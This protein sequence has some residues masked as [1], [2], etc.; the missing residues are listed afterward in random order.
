MRKPTQS[1]ESRIKR[2][3]FARRKGYVFTPSD[4]LDLARRS[5][6]DVSLH[7]LTVAGIIRRVARG[8]YLY[9]KKDH[10]LLGELG[11]S[12]EAIVAALAARDHVRMQPSGAY[13]ANMLRLSEQVPAKVVFVTD[14]RARKMKFGN[15]VIE[16]RH[17]TP[18]RMVAGT[19]GLVIAALRYLGKTHVSAAR[20]AHLREIL[21]PEDRKRLLLDLPSAP[22]WLHS[23][24]RFIAGKITS[25]PK[26]ARR[27]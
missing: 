5:A 3:I 27:S 7:R 9:P 8:F 19:S 18:R 20:I 17:T 25:R 6:V 15:L 21:S 13:A 23:H 16:F 26:G 24:L 11:P 1:I 14:G 22:V 12:I 2:R 10:P 4:F